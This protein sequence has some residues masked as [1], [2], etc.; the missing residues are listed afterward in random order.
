MGVKS[1]RNKAKNFI[2]ERKSFLKNAYSRYQDR[3]ENIKGRIHYAKTTSVGELN[4]RLSELKES[5]SPIDMARVVHGLT[6]SSIWLGHSYYRY[7]KTT[8]DLKTA[9]H[10]LEFSQE[11]E[12]ILKIIANPN[13]KLPDHISMQEVFEVVFKELEYAHFHKSYHPLVYSRPI[14]TT[15]VLISGVL[16]E[17]FSTPAFERAAIELHRKHGIKYIC[18]EVKGMKGVET[19]VL[20]LENQLREYI[21]QNPKEK[22]W[23]I[24]FSKGAIDVLHY[25]KHNREFAN[26]HIVGLSTIAGPILGSEHTDHKLLKGLSL[27][28]DFAETRGIKNKDVLFKEIYQSLSASFQGPWFE[29]NHKKLPKLKFYTSL[30]LESSWY[31]SHVWMILTKTFFQSSKPNDGIVDVEHAHFPDY[32]KALNLGTYPGHHLIGQRSSHFP[33]ESLIEAHLIVL[34]KL[35]LLD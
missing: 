24:G 28:H 35:G 13:K 8:L 2:D 10:D 34:N 31:E 22:L 14:K 27:I 5:K 15:I 16:N 26:K 7:L 1:L 17:I 33:Q 3:R 21:E 32:F 20:L 9:L 11:D 23:I 12:T 29:N 30:A 6:N 4:K 25:L 18:P 19:N